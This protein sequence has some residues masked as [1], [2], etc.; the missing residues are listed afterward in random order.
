[1]ATSFTLID[2]IFSS[3]RHTTHYWDCPTGTVLTLSSSC[4]SRVS[5]VLYSFFQQGGQWTTA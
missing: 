5:P 4:G 3:S 2:T 1:M